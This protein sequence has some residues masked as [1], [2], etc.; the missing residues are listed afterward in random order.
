MK[1]SPLSKLVLVAIVSALMVYLYSK[2]EPYT[3]E[4][5]CDGVKYN[6]LRYHDWAYKAGGCLTFYDEW[7]R[8]RSMKCGCDFLQVR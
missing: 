5:R 2:R 8:F 6:D 3:L 1:L 7:G 4:M